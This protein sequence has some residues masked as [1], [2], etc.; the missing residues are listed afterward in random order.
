M[1]GFQVQG[2]ECVGSAGSAGFQKSARNEA[3]CR[4]GFRGQSTCLGF[5]GLALCLVPPTRSGRLAPF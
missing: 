3:I 4:L 5:R 2:A 1:R